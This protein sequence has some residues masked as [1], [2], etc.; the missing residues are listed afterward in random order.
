M[1]FSAAPEC[2]DCAA[3]ATTY[4]DERVLDF[5]EHYCVPVRVRVQENRRLADEYFVSWTP[6][7]ILTDGDGRTHYELVG[8]FPAAEFLSHLS[9]GV[10]KYNL[11]HR[12]FEKAAERFEEV[13]ERFAGSDAGAEALYWLGVVRFKSQRDLAQLRATWQQLA[14][15]YPTSEWTK[16]TRI[17][18]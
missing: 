3:D 12:Y 7:V 17:P 14:N 6:T 5:I 16:R 10:G 8:H 15:E 13:A 9:L 11:N 2:G 4:A 18:Y 1:V